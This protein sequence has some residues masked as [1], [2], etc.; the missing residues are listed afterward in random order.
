MSDSCRNH[1][2]QGRVM[3]PRH[4]RQ[5]DMSANAPSVADGPDESTEAPL[6]PPPAFTAVRVSAETYARIVAIQQRALL[7]GVD[8]LPPDLRAK[9]LATHG[10]P[11]RRKAVTHATVV[12]WAMDA[13]DARLRSADEPAAT[14]AKKGTTDG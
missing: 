6:A 1:L 2:R 9:L 8:G 12:E 4:P 5:E 13:L 14:P 7:Q 10:E 3:S 11:G